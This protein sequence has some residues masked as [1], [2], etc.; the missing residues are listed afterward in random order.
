MPKI[1]ANHRL[2]LVGTF[3]TL[4]LSSCGIPIVEQCDS[5]TSK[6]ND[7]E[8]S[9]DQEMESF[10]E[11]MPT[12]MNLESLKTFAS[13]Y[14]E[15]VDKITTKI[16]ATATELTAL[17]LP[18]ETLSGYRDSYAALL[19]R[20]SQAIQATSDAMDM[21]LK[22]EK[23]VDLIPVMIG[24]QAKLGTAFTDLDKLST[25]S[26]TLTTQINDYCKEKSQ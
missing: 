4:G 7:S 26:D 13:G 25:E 22:V 2:I 18:D 16:D 11:K 1:Q 21:I 20:S 9:I 10:S 15:T 14:T 24:F 19:P 12:E 6:I 5:L 23:E 8:A 3:L 17:K